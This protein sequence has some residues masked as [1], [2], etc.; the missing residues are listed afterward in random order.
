MLPTG[1]ARWA[2]TTRGTSAGPRQIYDARGFE[3]VEEREHVSVMRRAVLV[4]GG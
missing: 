3:S 2:V 1:S 4:G